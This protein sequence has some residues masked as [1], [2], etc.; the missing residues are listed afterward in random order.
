MRKEGS[1]DS[2]LS[3][4]AA[5]LLISFTS[6]LLCSAADF[7]V[8]GPA[9]PVAAHVGTSVVLS[10]SLGLS[11]KAKPYE[12]RW[13]KRDAYDSPVLLYKD[14]EVQEGAA[15]PQ[16]RNRAFLVGILENG[17][18]SLQL[19]NLRAQD[20]GEYT[21]MVKSLTWY[22]KASANL[23]VRAVGS[24]PLLSLADAGDQV[25]VTCVSDGWSPKPKLTWRDREGRELNNSHISY[26]KV[27]EGLVTVSS[28]VLHSSSGS[29]W[30][31]CSVGLSD[32]EM[33][34]SRVAPFKGFW[35]EAFI[36]SLTLSLIVIITLV[37]LLVLV[38]Q[39][40]LPHCSSRKNAKMAANSNESIPEETLP[41]TEKTTEMTT[42]RTLVSGQSSQSSAPPVSD[43]E[44]KPKSKKFKKSKVKQAHNNMVRTVNHTSHFPVDNAGS[45]CIL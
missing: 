30:I 6:V 3:A 27:S 14:L 4:M 38:R 26:R 20:T 8:L 37:V 21:C 19:E 35:R 24:H 18:I 22:D 17:N 16:Y 13:Y 15:D 33:M 9:V 32:E 29:D 1:K 41:L 45:V 7:T 28:W 23:T 36:S 40:L 11:V 34:Q 42:E 12:V 10:C 43:E 31:S 5:V 2:I 25:N 44:K 39:D